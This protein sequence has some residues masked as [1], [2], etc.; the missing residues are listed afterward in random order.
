MWPKT[1]Q[2]RKS[3]MYSGVSTSIPGVVPVSNINHRRGSSVGDRKRQR[4]SAPS[5]RTGMAGRTSTRAL[6][7]TRRPTRLAATAHPEFAFTRLNR[8]RP[9]H[10]VPSIVHPVFACSDSPLSQYLDNRHGL[11]ERGP[12][13][14]PIAARLGLF[15]ALRL[16]VLPPALLLGGL[17]LRVLPHVRP[18]F[19]RI[20]PLWR[21]FSA[22]ARPRAWSPS[23]SDP[24][25][26]PPFV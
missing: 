8:R 1:R 10:L 11:L 18:F 15:R 20:V 16:E 19:P 23:C 5:S 14:C 9:S 6:A 22:H 26:S 2:L 24:T 17:P 3:W 12:G 13:R 4:G 25:S 7:R 21:R